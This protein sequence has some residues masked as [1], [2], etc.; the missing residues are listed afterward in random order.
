MKNRFDALLF[1]MDGVLIDVSDSYRTAI[2]RTAS[3]FLEREVNIDEVK[4]IKERVG[5]NNDWDA[6]YALIANTAVPY[7]MVK[8]VFQKLYWGERNKTGLINNER[9]LISKKILLRLRA[10]YR[11][12]GI[13]TGRPRVEALYVMNKF[14]ITEIFETLVAK[15]DSEREKPFPDPLIAAQKN[16]GS[17]IPIYIGDSPSDVI[18]ARSA[19]MPC[20]YIGARKIG[21]FPLNNISQVIKFLL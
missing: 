19:G 3:Y 21:T 11:K 14:K 15:E 6:T 10:K 1:D 18:A 7:L 16:I 5:M 2:Q 9:L 17:K 13:A 20:I 8:E 4:A 12:L